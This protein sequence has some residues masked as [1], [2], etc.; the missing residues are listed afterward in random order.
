MSAST[1]I[2]GIAI[3]MFPQNSA[4]FPSFHYIVASPL[5]MFVLE[6]NR[7]QKEILC[8]EVLHIAKR[9]RIQRLRSDSIILE[10]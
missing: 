10:W 4:T 6:W 3:S 5:E 9:T 7:A 2:R 8:P 1:T